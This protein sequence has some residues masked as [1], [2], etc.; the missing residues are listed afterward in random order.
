MIDVE[1]AKMDNETLINQVCDFLKI[2]RPI[3]HSV[4]TE[5]I[6]KELCVARLCKSVG[7]YCE[8]N[9]KSEFFEFFSTVTAQA[10]ADK[11]CLNMRIAGDE[12]RLF[13]Y[14]SKNLVAEVRRF[15]DY[16]SIDEAFL[17]AFHFLDSY[18]FL[19]KY[20]NKNNH[21]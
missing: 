18:K 3:I 12:L 9:Y 21:E 17:D 1:D 10:L 5:E 20:L 6:L 4:T 19:I 11:L 8:Y 16:E 2:K 13:K 7:L 15:L 14:N